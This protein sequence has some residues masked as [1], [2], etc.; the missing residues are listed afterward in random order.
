V[1][2]WLHPSIDVSCMCYLVRLAENNRDALAGR[3]E[4]Y[5][6]GTWGTVCDDGFND[7][8][9]KVVCN[10]LGFGYVRCVLTAVECIGELRAI[11][12]C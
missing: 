11:T 6:H 2:V 7:T 1:E 5:R 10:E 9:A 4:V 3:L 8:A 12:S